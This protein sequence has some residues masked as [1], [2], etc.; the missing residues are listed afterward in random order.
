VAPLEGI[1]VLWSVCEIEEGLSVYLIKQIGKELEN[2][3]EGLQQ[4]GA[5]GNS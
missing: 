4:Q 3:I 1:C 5:I 2:I